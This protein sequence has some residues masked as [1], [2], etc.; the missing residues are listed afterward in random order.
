MKR[1]EEAAGTPRMPAAARSASER[2]LAPGKTRRTF[3]VRVATLDDLLALAHYHRRSVS[4]EL[5]AALQSH[6]TTDMAATRKARK[7]T[8][9]AA[10]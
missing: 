7:L 3:V 6:I 8:A 9:K 5:E 2:E 4:D 1:N 10:Q